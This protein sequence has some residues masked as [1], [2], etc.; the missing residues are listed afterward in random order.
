MENTYCGKSCAECR[1]QESLGCPGCKA[2]PGRAFV[3]DCDL[4]KCCTGKGQSSCADCAFSASCAK[5][6]ARDRIQ[7]QRLNSMEAEKRKNEVLARRAPVLEKWLKIMFWLLIPGIVLSL[8]ASD[9]VAENAPGLYWAGQVLSTL[10]SV[11]YGVILLRLSRE[12]DQYRSAG[13]CMLIGIAVSTVA[14]WIFAG[15]EILG[16]ALV[17]SI[18]TNVLSLVAA[19]HELMA[20]STVMTGIDDSMAGK[21]ETLWRWYIGSYGAFVGGMVVMLVVPVLGLMVMTAGSIGQIVV[22]VLKM[23]YLKRSARRFW[24]YS[25]QGV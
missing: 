14:N 23:V 9:A 5:L 19:Y 16:W 17:F 20:H 25:V 21:W 3:G 6:W 15:R 2:G 13:I 8:V 18:G 4:A 11:A 12:E 1:E 24:E 22:G 10:C 7:Q